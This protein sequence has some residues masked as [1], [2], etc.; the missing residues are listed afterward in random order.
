MRRHPWAVPLLAAFLLA[1]TISACSDDATGSDAVPSSSGSA[2]PEGE[3]SAAPE[4]EGSAAPEVDQPGTVELVAAEPSTTVLAGTSEQ[5]SALQMSQ[6]LFT[7]S[8]VVVLA[9]AGD[10]ASVT[11]AAEQAASLGVPMLLTGAEDDDALGAE[12]ERLEADTL[13]TVGDG[14][15]TAAADLDLEATA[16]P[17]DLPDLTAAD[18]QPGTVVL[19]TGAPGDAAALATAAA[20]GAAVVTAPTG[21]PRATPE[22]ITA[23]SEAAPER[24]IAVGPTFGDQSQLTGRV[25]SAATGA[26]LPGGGQ[27]VLAD[28][29]YVA[30]Y[31]HPG[32]AG[33]GVLGEQPLE[34]ALARAKQVAGEYDPHSD[35]PVIP[36]FEII[37]TVASSSAGRDGNYSNEVDAEFLRPWIEAAEAEGVYVLLD[38]QPGTTDFLT[39][40]QQYETLLA[41]PNVGLALDPEWRLEPGQ[42]HMAQIGTVSAA[43]V[44]T[45]SDWLATFTRENQLPQK[46]L[47]LHQFRNSMISERTTL[48]TDHDELSVVIHADGHGPP[49]QKLETWN[50][51]RVDAP[52]EVSWAWKNFYD[53][54]SPTFTPAETMSIDPVPVLVSYQ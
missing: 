22:A 23:L 31:G 1:P 6:A 32:T 15:V 37:T 53:E 3:G 52:A 47:V 21:D 4:G 50:A 29:R 28:R 24:V 18:T 26:Q 44:N 46:M 10:A 27:L 33:L 13:F 41:Y 38:L 45:V 39:Q 20:A 12:L 42:R 5:E 30:L 49:G 16:D 9:D 34:G 25:A 40:A 7:R 2:A 36:T 43:E 11:T 8:P 19:T 54:D 48:V 17:E 14:A 51:L 35:L